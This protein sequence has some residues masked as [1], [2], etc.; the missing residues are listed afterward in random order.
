MATRIPIIV[1]PDGPNFALFDPSRIAKTGF[2][3]TFKIN[4][5]VNK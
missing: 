1:G 3:E 2:R 4:T 5:Q